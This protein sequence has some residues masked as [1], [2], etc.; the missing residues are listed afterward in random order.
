MLG[1]P[2]F[3][4]R[5]NAAVTWGRDR[6]PVQSAALADHLIDAVEPLGQ[7]PLM[8]REGTA[9]GTREWVVSH[10]PFFIVYEVTE[11]DVHVLRLL[12]QHQQWPPS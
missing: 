8:G 6:W 12:H 1:L 3:H 9:P 2:L 11:T 4:F 10:Y 5:Q 7:F